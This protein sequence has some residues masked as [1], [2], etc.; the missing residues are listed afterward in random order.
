MDAIFLTM[1]MVNM[2][3]VMNAFKREGLRDKVKMI[4]S[5]AR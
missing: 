3:N 2:R 4:T 1:T 5:G